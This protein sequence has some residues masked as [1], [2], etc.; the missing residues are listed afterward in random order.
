MNRF[1]LLSSALFL[2]MFGTACEGVSDDAGGGDAADSAGGTSGSCVEGECEDDST[3]PDPTGDCSEVIDSC[4]LSSGLPYACVERFALGINYAWHNFATDFGGLDAWSQNGVTADSATYASELADMKENGAQVVRWWMFPDFRGEGVQF[5]GNGDPTGISAQAV[6]DIQTALDLA[7]AQDVYLVLT[8]FSFDNFRPTHDVEGVTIR[9]MAPMVQDATRRSNLIENVVRPVAQA[10]AD[11]P[12]AHR[13]MG[14]D[15]INEPEWAIEATDGAPSGEQFEPNEELTAV[16]LADMKALINESLAVLRQE[17]DWALL[18]VGWAAAKWAWAFDDITDV[19][20]DQPHIY[21]WV[22]E[23]WPYTSSPS[24]LGYGDRPIVMGEFHLASMPF[25]DSTD[26]TYD[27]IL[28]SWY[29]NG[30]GGAWAWQYIENQS[31]LGLID[32]FSQKHSC[33][34]EF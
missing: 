4:P 26:A 25:S 34:T 31:S 1:L 21:S 5:D 23:W 8:I 2:S 22:N 33:E 19:D 9:G 11:S 32:A 7:E 18:S 6:T 27:E 24:E 12:N 29:Q 28:S 10:V 3:D 17:T 13:L 16:S 14:W 15:V 20:F 30:Y